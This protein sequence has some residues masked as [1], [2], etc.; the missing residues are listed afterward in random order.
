MQNLVYY[1]PLG[2]GAPS[3]VSRKLFSALISKNLHLNIA[4]FPQKRNKNFLDIVEN[5][6]PN[7]KIY[8]I[9]NLFQNYDEKL[10]MHFT[11]SPLVYPNRK[12]ILYLAALLNRNKRNK[13]KLIINYHGEPSTEFKI[14][15]KNHDLKSLVYVPNYILT[16]YIMRSA[17]VIIVN[18]F[19][20]RDLFVTKYKARNIIVI[21]NGID[22][23]WSSNSNSKL[24]KNEK[25]T[26]Y[27]FYHGRLD[28]EKGVELL[29]KAFSNVLKVTNE[30]IKLFI[31]GNGK[32]RNYLEKLCNNLKIEND[33][34]F[35]GN[36]SQTEIKFYLSIA[37]IAV[38]PSILDGFSLSVLE[39]FSIVN[40]PVIYS[41]KIGIDDF[42]RK[43]GF[44]FYT[45]NPSIEEITSMISKILKND[46]DKKIF[47]RQKEFASH[48]TWDRIV[49][50]YIKVYQDLF[51]NDDN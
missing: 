43:S 26:K 1:Y 21:P 11:M 3:E 19:M 5:T 13:L 51:L 18:S 10:L 29:I 38:Y 41:N 31:G 8:L 6:Y 4:I 7:T 34:T 46:Y 16:P 42:V 33:V 44:E 37:D 30:N 9:N 27:L 14:K 36:L 2:S 20:I 40:G 50:E 48:Y 15:L 24:K 32:Q 35:L 49:N 47:L 39:A 28:P 45:F 25:N 17:D 23:S 22:S 12:F